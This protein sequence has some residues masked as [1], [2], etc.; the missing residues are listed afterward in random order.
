MDTI[1]R[2]YSKIEVLYRNETILK[3]SF[4]KK[5]IQLTLGFQKV[6]SISSGHQCVVY[7]IE[8]ECSLR[9]FVN[10][11]FSMQDILGLFLGRF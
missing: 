3:N 1:L 8:K 10:F 6:G 7:K 9:N 5:F 4:Y 2:V 11:H